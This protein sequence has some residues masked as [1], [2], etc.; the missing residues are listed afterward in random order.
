MEKKELSRADGRKAPFLNKI[1][2]TRGVGWCRGESKSDELEGYCK[3]TLS[4]RTE[5]KEG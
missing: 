4:G 2:E 1:R 5:V 3:R